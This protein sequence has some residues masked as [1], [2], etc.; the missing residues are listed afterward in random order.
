MKRI[1]RF[2]GVLVITL[3]LTGCAFE[4][5]NNKIY[6]T[7]Y[8][9]TFI[10]TYLLGTDENVESIYPNDTDPDKY[11]LTKKLIKEYSSGKI[12]IYNGLS[13]EKEYAKKFVNT[14]SKLNIIDASENIKYEYNIRETWFSPNNFMMLVRNI[15]ERLIELSTS[16]EEIKT[17]NANFKTLEQDIS[18]MDAY[19]RS[20]AKDA[21]KNEKKPTIISANGDFKY[22]EDYGFEVISL[23]DNISDTNLATIKANFK[24]KNYEN[25]IAFEGYEN[26][27]LVESL[28]NDCGAKIKYI[29]P[30]FSLSNEDI[31]KNETYI[32][33]MNSYIETIKNIVT[34]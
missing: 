26:S 19:L 4:K 5:H 16:Q 33:L 6:T 21:T 29:N 1:A 34:K 3:L 20:V 28:V 31:L 23:E 7:S 24:N 30:I 15:K 27:E 17:I 32:T 25:I 18:N 22:L 8:P 13:A 10:T 12:F 2:L 11:I 14:N 9:I